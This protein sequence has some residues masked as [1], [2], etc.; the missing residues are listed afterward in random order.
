[1]RAL[2]DSNFYSILYY[3][4]VIWLTPDISSIMKQSL[5]S[6]S[7]NALR[8]CMLTNCNEISFERIHMKCK[9]STPKQIALYQMSLKLHKTINEM[10]LSITS[11]HAIL[12]NQLVCSTRQL[13]FEI[14]RNNSFKIGMNTVSNKFYHVNKLIGLDALD[15]KFVHFKKLM[16][17]QLLKYGKT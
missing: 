16:K 17:I 5:L 8:S 15:M 12:L 1:M 9:K 3:N 6:V 13:K 11:E 14:L 2:L 4:S 10:H 7:A